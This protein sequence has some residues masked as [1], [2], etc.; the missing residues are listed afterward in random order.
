MY[1]SSGKRAGIH[2]TPEKTKEIN[3]ICPVCGK[4]LVI[5]V[6]NRVEELADESKGFKPASAKHF[7]KVL[8]LHEIIALSVGGTVN[9][10]KVWE[11]Y[12]SLIENFGNEFNILLEISKEKL[13]ARNF[14]E[15]L[16]DLILKNR[17]GKIKVTPGYDGVY[18][19]AVTSGKQETLF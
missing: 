4:P 17:E 10:K 9:S 18:G 7:F 8:P 16:I 19:V 15:K 13:L 12:N 6:D 14:N 1:N 5:G 11:I 2:R 3:G